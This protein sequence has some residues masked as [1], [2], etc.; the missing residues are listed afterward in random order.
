MKFKLLII[1]IFASLNLAAQPSLSRIEV[2]GANTFEFDQINGVKVRKLIGNVRLRQ[3]NVLL[4]CDSAYQYEERNYVEAYRNVHIVA[5]DSV[6]IYGDVLKYE[7]NTKKARVEKNV[8]MYDQT[9][10]LTTPDLDYDMGRGFAYY[11]NG[12]KIV[13]SNSVLVSRYGYY[14]TRSKEFFFKRNVVLTSP[15]YTIYSDTLKQHTITNITYMLGPTQIL[16]NQDSIYCERGYYNNNTNQAI[17]SKKAFI[18][19][20][21]NSLYADSIFFDRNIGL[22]KAYFNLK[23]NDPK[24]KMQIFGDYGELRQVQKQ[25]FVT[26]R[27]YAKKMLDQND[28]MYV[29][30]DTIYSYQQDSATGQAQ[31]VKAYNQ[32]QILK[33]DLQAVADSMV[34]ED[35]DSTITLFQNPLMWSGNNQMSGDTITLF[36]NN[37]LLD[38]FVIN[39]NAF[40]ASRET[41]KDFNQVKGRVMNGLFIDSKIEQVHVVGNS[42]SIFYAKSEKDTTYIGVNLIDC[43][44]MRYFLKDNRLVKSVF[45][46]QPEATFYPIGELRPEQLKLKGFK[47]RAQQRPTLKTVAEYFI[48]K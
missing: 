35:I 12:G 22:G 7:G 23:V 4:S 45:I 10:K 24:N 37:G 27:A 1:T 32:V 11:T 9:M 43:S 5:N 44:E 36:L 18:Q 20:P 19:S 8:I 30:A 28:S 6:H 14:D 13:N 3:D 2:L 15:N 38:H 26:K 17:L 33:F 16:S 46:T 25:S 29:L 41:A 42:Q 48:K 39:G 40:L 21:G 34:Y 47:W 31:R